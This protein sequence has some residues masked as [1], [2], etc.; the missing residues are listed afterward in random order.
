V[1]VHACALQDLQAGQMDLFALLRSQP[2]V[3]S[4]GHAHAMSFDHHCLIKR[5]GNLLQRFAWI[6]AVMPGSN[7]VYGGK[8][9]YLIYQLLSFDILYGII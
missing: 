6:L 2:G 1:Y 4:A 7:L 5:E 8:L 9:K 3:M